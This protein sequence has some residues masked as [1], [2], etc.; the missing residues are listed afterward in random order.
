MDDFNKAVLA[1]V[2]LVALFL[3]PWMQWRIARKQVQMQAEIARLQV[4][5]QSRIATRQIADNISSKRQ[6][7][8][9]ELRKDAAEFLTVAGRIQELKRP[10]VKRII[11]MTEVAD[12]FG[13]RLTAEM[14]A[15]ELGTRIML[16][17]NP[18]EA[19]HN[20]LVQ[21]IGEMASKG[22]QFDR[23]YSPAD[24]QQVAQAFNDASQAVIEHLQAILK[25]EWERVKRG[26]V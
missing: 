24:E 7:W 3:G 6:N 16:R 12:D 21:L 17:L 1:M 18:N 2:A 19:E 25:Q 5:T 9:D 14:R 15:K 20:R 23:Q 13:E 26:D 4:E 22:Y 8:I 11:A 10:R